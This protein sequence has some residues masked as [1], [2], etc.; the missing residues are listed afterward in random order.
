MVQGRGGG[1]ALLAQGSGTQQ[2]SLESALDAMY[3]LVET[4]LIR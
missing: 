2:D 3:C 1:N 4:S